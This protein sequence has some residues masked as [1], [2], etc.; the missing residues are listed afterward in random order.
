[1]STRYGLGSK[2]L[3]SYGI[4]STPYSQAASADTEVG[5][6]NEDIEPPN[7]NPQ[8]PM[9]TGGGGRQPYVQSPDP[10]EHEFDIPSVIHTPDA[11]FEI[12][13]GSRAQ[14]SQTDYTEYLFTEADVLPTATFR[15]VQTDVGLVAYYVGAKADLTIE[16]SLG[17]PLQATLSVVAAEHVY[18]PAE[19]P[20][21]VSP[22]LPTDVS[23]Y[24]SHMQGNLS[25]SDG[26]TKEVATING[27]TYGVSNGLEAQH[28]GSDGTGGDRDAYSVAETTAADKYDIS[29]DM[30]V[31]DTDLYQHAY[32]NGALVDAEIPFA[33]Q[34]SSGTI[35]DGVILRANQCRLLEGPVPRP[36]E[37]VIEG[38]VGLA[39]QGGVEIEIREA[40]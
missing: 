15:H 16:W 35:V 26:L 12:A 40:T 30:N 34:V 18:D 28:H 11:P 4:E 25:I 2:G 38:S 36:G 19:S 31:T 29:V 10:K 13:L 27:G 8:T 22:S 6:T 5:I 32:E 14:T 17:D 37:G 24:R 33:R 1:M 21:A 3:V 39:P 9:P 7:E 23:P 20:P